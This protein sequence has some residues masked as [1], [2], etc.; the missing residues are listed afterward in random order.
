MSH[1]ESEGEK[2]QEEIGYCVEVELPT[3]VTIKERHQFLTLLTS[4][5]S[6]QRAEVK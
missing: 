1:E 6:K 4:Q 3:K 5:V 2:Q